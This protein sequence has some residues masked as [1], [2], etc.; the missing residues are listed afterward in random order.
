MR[1]NTQKYSPE[2]YILLAKS[3]EYTLFLI[4]IAQVSERLNDQ[5]KKNRR[6]V[7]HRSFMTRNN[8]K[9]DL[10]ERF[11]EKVHFSAAKSFQRSNCPNHNK[12]QHDMSIEVKPNH[13]QF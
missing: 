9:N 1:Y 6:S 3:K 7:F 10:L 4:Y 12:I 11:R 5:K 13:R 2:E 8:H